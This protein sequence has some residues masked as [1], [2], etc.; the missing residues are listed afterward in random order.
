[1]ANMTLSILGIY[2]FDDTIF[3]DL[4]VPEGMDKNSLINKILMDLGELNVVYSKPDILK[5]AIGTWSISRAITWERMWNVAQ[6]EYNPLENYDR[7][8]SW[9]DQG[10][11][12]KSGSSNGQ[13]T[14][15][16]TVTEKVA[17]FNSESLVNAKQSTGNGSGTTT[18]S[19]SESGTDTSTRTGRTHG[20]IGITTSQHLLESELKVAPKLDIY[21]WI[22]EEFKQY[23]CIMVY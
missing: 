8:E 23:F 20:N 16:S 9:T 7:Q 10:S 12:Q 15:N 19:E 17:G 5:A 2:K 11:H 6:I 18:N 1:M 4:N 13:S 21:N 3:D 22:V 14:G